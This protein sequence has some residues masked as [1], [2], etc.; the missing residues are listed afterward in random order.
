M[1]EGRS[2][3]TRFIADSSGY[4][5]G[6]SEM[7]SVLK[8]LNKDLKDNQAEQKAASKTIKDAEKEITKLTKEINK[9]GDE[10]GKL[11]KR[12]EEL[13]RQISNEKDH[14]EKLKVAQAQIQRQI[15]E[16]NDKI[17]AQKDALEKLDQAYN[18]SIS[19]AKQLALEVGGLAAAGTAALT[20]LFEY[21]HQAAVWADSL[22]TMSQKT[23]IAVTELQKF[24]YASELIDVSAETVAGALNRMTLNMQSAKNSAGTQREAFEALGV[25]YE[26]ATGKLRDRETVFYELIDALGQVKS[27]TERDALAMNIFGRS[28]TELNPLIKGGAQTLKE[29]GAQAEAAGLILSDETVKGLHNFNDEIDL[30]KAK[31]SQI[32][33]IL[34]GQ[35]TPAFE[36]MLSVADSL[37]DKVNEL[38]QSG[39][40]EKMARQAGVYITDLAE[41]LE[42]LI[43]WCWQYKEAIAAGT[44]ALVSFK[45]AMSI[46][47][48]VTALI[49]GFK[50]LSVATK[51]ETADMAALNVVMD[52]NPIGLVLGL[53]GALAGALQ[54]LSITTQLQTEK[55]GD[56]NRSAEDCLKSIMEAEKAA[57]SNIEQT[58]AQAKTVESLAKEYDSLINKTNLTAKEQKN[59][60]AV[61]QELAKSLGTTLDDLKDQTGAYRDLTLE[62]DNYL[63]KLREQV[64]F[65][66]DRNRLTAAYSSFDEATEKVKTATDAVNEQKKAIKELRNTELDNALKFVQNYENSTD[67][68]FE[69]KEEYLRKRQIIE[70]S[71]EYYEKLEEEERKLSEL[72]QTQGDYNYQVLKAADAVINYEG[73]LGSTID[74]EQRFTELM[75]E[76]GLATDADIKYLDGLKKQIEKTDDAA[77][78]T[79]TSVLEIISNVKALGNEI[80]TAISDSLSGAEEI[81]STIDKLKKEVKDNGSVSL[82]TL[83]D[84]IKK[85][86]ELTDAVNGY[87]NG[88]NDESQIIK[89]LEKAY[90]D[91]IANYDWALAQKKLSQGNFNSDMLG[92]MQELVD[93]Y[94]EKYNIDLTNFT[95]ITAAKLAVQEQYLAE[96][97]KLSNQYDIGVENGKLVYYKDGKKVEDQAAAAAAVSGAWSNYSTFDPQKFSDDLMKRMSGILGGNSGGNIRGLA[98]G[99]SSS[100][101]SSSTSSSKITLSTKD[102][103]GTGDTYAA[104]YLDWM[105]KIKALGKLSTED[106]IRRL[107]EL[108]KRTDL[109]AEDRYKIELALYNA[110]EK[111]NK[112]QL[113]TD[114]SR[115]E[116]AA[117][118]YRAIMQGRIDK[119]K[120]LADEAKKT[121][122]KEIAAID[123]VMKKRQEEQDDEKRRKEIKSIDDQLKYKQLDDISRYELRKRRQEL[124]TEQ[125]EVDYTRSMEA[126]KANISARA[127]AF[128]AN[129]DAA[130]A[131]L[132]AA[133]DKGTYAIAKQAGTLT[134]SQVINHNNTQQNIT[135]MQNSLSSNQLVEKLKKL[136]Y[137]G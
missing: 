101:S 94:K 80:D 7:Q 79:S 112:E 10:D 3:V 45:I 118:A 4:K 99:S 29:L 136:I 127:E 105:N 62:I 27:E 37:L 119:Q 14:I 8:G 53:A 123:A 92:K 46:G 25:S 124:L 128:Q 81:L 100:S 95:N 16:T 50:A 130:I 113:Q 82:S 84:I 77:E 108:K 129:S 26:D 36:G 71:G 31:G 5:K 59:L 23:G 106:E 58:E 43:G 63:E 48:L 61:A 44:A 93:E 88:L 56:L 96:Y 111:L 115:M 13:N 103:T 39:E 86:P 135:L 110:R 66:N 114:K 104:A 24:Q 54:M 32:G 19:N 67:H 121:A 74:K 33:H 98:S 97:K 15:G 40:L 38:A 2:F 125:A 65:E 78:S 42:K 18:D 20:A 11:S 6:I 1:S 137:S 70:Q 17:K 12:I 73:K 87:I 35:T 60:D 85:Y 64:R 57:T 47:N 133:I 34:A 69:D 126:K 116:L 132:N 102:A 52:A 75:K 76:A 134:S 122:D 55:F 49:A 90:K 120:E 21:S 22:E 131:R 51:A 30:L 9:H 41:K 109:N 107:N 89:G 68:S 72:K 117:E 28:A 91:D 83:S